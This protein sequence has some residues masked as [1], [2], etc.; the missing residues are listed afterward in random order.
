MFHETPSSSACIYDVGNTNGE[1]CR[2]RERERGRQ[3]DTE[4]NEDNI[5][6]KAG[7]FTQTE[8]K[9]MIPKLPVRITLPC[10]RTD[11]CNESVGHIIL[12]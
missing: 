7:K 5:L 2:I 8:T 9:Q 10:F 1:Q 4:V 6:I 3:T 11:H 12:F